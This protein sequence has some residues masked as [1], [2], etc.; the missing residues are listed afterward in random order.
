MSHPFSKMFHPPWLS[1][2]SATRI[3][4]HLTCRSRRR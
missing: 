3:F 1:D 2:Q 4:W